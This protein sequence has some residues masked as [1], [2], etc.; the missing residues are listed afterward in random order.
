MNYVSI[1][2]WFVCCFCFFFLSKEL[3]FIRSPGLKIR[4]A[5]GKLV[6]ILLQATQVQGPPLWGVFPCKHTLHVHEVGQPCEQ[7]YLSFGLVL[8]C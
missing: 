6:K 1:V 4:L 8:V 3:L 5:P 7:W 2:F